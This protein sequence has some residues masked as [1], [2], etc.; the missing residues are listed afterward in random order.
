MTMKSKITIILTVIVTALFILAFL[1]W[2]NNVYVSQKCHADLFQLKELGAAEASKEELTKTMGRL[3]T[4]GYRILI[5]CP[6]PFLKSEWN[7]VCKMD[8]STV[9]TFIPFFGL[10]WISFGLWVILLRPDKKVS[11]NFPFFRFHNAIMVTLGLL[12]T[13]WGLIMIGF[14]LDPDVSDLTHCLHTALFSTFVALIW[15][16]IVAL[17]M[18]HIIHRLYE[19]VTGN[20]IEGKEGTTFIERLEKHVI[21][22]GECIK[23]VVL[24]VGNLMESIKQAILEVGNLMNSIKSLVK[25]INAIGKA[26][27]KLSRI[28]DES[29]AKLETTT[30]R[31][32]SL[33]DQYQAESQKKQEALDQTIESLSESQK[34][35]TAMTQKLQSSYVLIDEQRLL[36]DLKDQENIELDY[37]L[38]RIKE[39]FLNGET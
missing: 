34:I 32:N 23:K 37:K 38:S 9:S 2:I 35:I 28:L 5:P 17:L 22:F 21:S 14:Y 31:H 26:I 4:F 36:L 13:I 30:D 12:G 19:W 15:V 25:R 20:I 7:A 33:M 39:V 11:I 6:I 3:K 8:L 18:K 16:Y 10:G 27:D 29:L 1:M 24:E